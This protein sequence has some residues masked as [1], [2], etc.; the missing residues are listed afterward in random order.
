MFICV[1]N[2]IIK[3]SGIVWLVVIV[4]ASSM[5][6]LPLPVESEQPADVLEKDSWHQDEFPKIPEDGDDPEME[7]YFATYENPEDGDVSEMQEDEIDPEMPEQDED[8]EKPEDSDDREISKDSNVL[9]FENPEDVPLQEFAIPAPEG[10]RY[11]DNDP[12]MPNIASYYEV[13]GESDDSEMW[14]EENLSEQVL[15]G[16]ITKITD[17]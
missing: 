5:K 11:E 4:M 12:G 10:M 17:A 9:A 3:M 7:A 14:D 15:K 16:L 1:S 6:A 8:S 2:A 13:A